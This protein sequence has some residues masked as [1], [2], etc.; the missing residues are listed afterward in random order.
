L[1]AR[2]NALP[3]GSP[4]GSKRRTVRRMLCLSALPPLSAIE[5]L[6]RHVVRECVFA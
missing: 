5:V 6:T 1:L 4:A 2:S 3:L